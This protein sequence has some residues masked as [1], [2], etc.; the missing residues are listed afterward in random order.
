MNIRNDLSENVWVLLSNNSLCLYQIVKHGYKINTNIP[1]SSKIVNAAKL[2]IMYNFNTGIL[3]NQKV[4]NFRLLGERFVLFF[5]L[6]KVL[7]TKFY[8]GSYLM[9]DLM[10]LPLYH[11]D[12]QKENYT[13]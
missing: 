7:I 12:D 5:G 10:F 8:P 13:Y 11:E 4:W 3:K 9:E 6:D 1:S 2:K